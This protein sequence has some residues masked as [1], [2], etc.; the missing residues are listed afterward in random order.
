MTIKP[1]RRKRLRENDANGNK[2]RSASRCKWNGNLDPGAF[3]IL[4]A[5]AK[6]DAALGQVLANGDFLL[7]STTANTG[8]DSGFDA[9]P[10]TSRNY[11][12]VLGSRRRDRR[13]RRFRLSLDPDR[14]TV[15][16]RTVPGYALANFEGLKFLFFEVNDLAALTKTAFHK[17]TRQS[18][19][20]FVGRGEIDIPKVAARLNDGDRVQEALG[21]MI[22]LGDDTGTGNFPV[23]TFALAT[24]GEFL[25][26]KN[27]FGEAENTTVTADQ[28]GLSDLFDGD[29][30]ITEPGSLNGHTK[31]DTVALA[32]AFGSHIVDVT[33]FSVTNSG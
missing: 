12:L 32:E 29:A 1:R 28:E 5:T 19:L 25:T 16:V 23:V 30:A 27:L 6:T 11:A 33:G 3:R 24:K 20:A 26:G 31:T 14:R 9:S 2:N 13:R 8:E 18:L 22:D 7:E 15:T 10:V 4:I 21:F 17:E